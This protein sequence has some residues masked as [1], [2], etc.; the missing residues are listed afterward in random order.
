M[1]ARA[2][3]QAWRNQTTRPIVDLVYRPSRFFPERG[4]WGW[5]QFLACV[6]A[7]ELGTLVYQ[8]WWRHV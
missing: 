8:I 2:A 5:C 4:Q 7:S 6:I 1:N 3:E